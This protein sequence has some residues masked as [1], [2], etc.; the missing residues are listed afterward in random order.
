MADFV[1]KLSYET[2]DTVF[3]NADID[4]K[5]N[6][7]LNTYLQIFYSSFPF[8]KTPN[9]AINNTWMTTGIKTTCKH[10]RELHLTSRDSNEPLQATLQ[11]FVKCHFGSQI[12]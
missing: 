4:T 12:K 5:L 2:W 6:S 1:M 8:K 9:T 3:S 10:T 11:S 7:F